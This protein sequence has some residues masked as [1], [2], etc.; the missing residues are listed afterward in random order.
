MAG[1]LVKIRHYIVE[2][3]RDHL[4]LVFHDPRYQKHYPTQP[5]ELQCDLNQLM[6]TSSAGN[7]SSHG[8]MDRPQFF[9]QLHTYTTT[10][11]FLFQSQDEI[12]G[13]MLLHNHV[14]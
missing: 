10:Q 4:D 8:T 9:F 3:L 11:L 6:L 14:Q 5:D 12:V 2:S 7:N 13:R 1:W